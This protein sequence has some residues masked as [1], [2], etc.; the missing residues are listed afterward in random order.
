ML[1]DCM[2]G[3]MERD[4][5]ARER[6]RVIDRLT[7][8]T[9]DY[10][11]SGGGHTSIT[12]GLSSR[13]CCSKF[14]HHIDHVVGLLAFVVIIHRLLKKLI[15]AA[16]KSEGQIVDGNNIIAEDS[17]SGQPFNQPLSSATNTPLSASPT[18]S[19]DVHIRPVPQAVAPE[20]PN[21]TKKVTRIQSRSSANSRA[22]EA[23]GDNVVRKRK[24][25]RP[26]SVK[27]GRL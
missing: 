21:M 25:S 23:S 8:T 6:E 24:F 14:P 27:E 15:K 11:Q 16:A 10:L 20:M 26:G 22:S 7:E 4:Q 5:R 13:S 12:G 18:P 1:S 19:E 17:E 2:N 3:F 9:P